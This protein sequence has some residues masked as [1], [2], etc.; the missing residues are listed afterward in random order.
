M[1]CSVELCGE[2]SVMGKHRVQP[3]TQLIQ[4]CHIR[5]LQ[6]VKVKI[7]LATVSQTWTS[8]LYS[9]CLWNMKVFHTLGK[10]MH[11]SFYI[12]IQLLYMGVS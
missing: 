5:K 10:Y 8:D 4:G 11:A 3:H 7:Q 2:T 6:H 1:T 9:V 12:C